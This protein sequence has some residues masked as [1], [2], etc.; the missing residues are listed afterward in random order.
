MMNF[1]NLVSAVVRLQNVVE[2]SRLSLTLSK[3][4]KILQVVDQSHRQLVSL[5]YLNGL[6]QK[7]TEPYWGCAGCGQEYDE[8]AN[9][10]DRCKSYK[11][12]QLIEEGF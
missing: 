1:M 5:R 7:M 10:C 11:Y 12:F 8:D 3:S 9:W 2:S 6:G 4:V